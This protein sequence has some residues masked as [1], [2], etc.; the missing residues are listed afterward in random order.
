ME[1][2]KVSARSSKFGRRS[3]SRSAEGKRR[4][5]DPGNRSGS[6]ESGG[7]SDCYRARIRRTG[8]DRSRFGPGVYGH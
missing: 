1:I 6:I 7:K 8:R 5:G 2:L 4:S 3:I